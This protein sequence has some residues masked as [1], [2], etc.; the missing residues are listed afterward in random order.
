ML[1]SSRSTQR[2]SVVTRL[3][4]EEPAISSLSMRRCHSFG[5]SCEAMTVAWRPSRAAMISN[6]STE[7]CVDIGV[8]MKSVD[9]Q[10]RDGLAGVHLLEVA[11]VPGDVDSVQVV[12][13]VGEVCMAK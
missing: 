1:G 13:D 8:V 7:F 9:Q 2:V 6:R 11:A 12:T 10:E 5:L 4:I 3:R